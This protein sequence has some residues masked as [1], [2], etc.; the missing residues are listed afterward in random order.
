MH[1]FECKQHATF[2]AQVDSAIVDSDAKDTL[3]SALSYGTKV[4]DTWLLPQF[5]K[6]LICTRGEHLICIDLSNT[7]LFLVFAFYPN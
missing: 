3:S 2:R 1:C 4:N 6:E 7:R 5:Y